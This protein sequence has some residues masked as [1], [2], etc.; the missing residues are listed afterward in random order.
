MRLA[1]GLAAIF[2]SFARD[3]FPSRTRESKLGVKET[4]GRLEW[5]FRVFSSFSSPFA[6]MDEGSSIGAL[7]R[8]T[9]HVLDEIERYYHAPD[10]IVTRTTDIAA[11]VLVNDYHAAQ[12]PGSFRSWFPAQNV[13]Q[14][15]GRCRTYPARS[16][17]YFHLGRQRER[18]ALNP[19]RI[20]SRESRPRTLKQR[21][22]LYAHVCF[23]RKFEKI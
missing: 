3:R 1:A 20:Y 16:G 7:S 13:L 10:I 14:R 9:S 2:R 4:R 23:L 17:T 22:T 11:P 19:G 15:S 21:S 8:M 5:N 12:G 18:S 6:K